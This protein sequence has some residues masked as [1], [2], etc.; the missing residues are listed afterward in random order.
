MEVL[1]PVVTMLSHLNE[2][3]PYKP[4]AST[5]KY[6][7]FLGKKREKFCLKL[8][9]SLNTVNMRYFPRYA[10]EPHP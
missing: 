10:T 1:K 8:I 9:F 2:E 6:T 7:K 3:V 5:Y 4:N